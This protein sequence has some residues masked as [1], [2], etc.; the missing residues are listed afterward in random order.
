VVNFKHEGCKYP[1]CPRPHKANGYCHP[2]NLMMWRLKTEE[3]RRQIVRETFFLNKA[4]LQRIYRPKGSYHLSR[5]I[6]WRDGTFSLVA[7]CCI[8]WKLDVFSSIVG[9][10]PRKQC[11]RCL[12][13]AKELSGG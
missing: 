4:W 1:N 5:K 11:G 13:I 2:H 10:D 12:K 3:I 9:T 7:A 8:S 6:E